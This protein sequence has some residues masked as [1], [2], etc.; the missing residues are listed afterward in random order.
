MPAVGVPTSSTAAAAGPTAAVK[1]P[2]MREDAAVPELREWSWNDNGT[3]S[4]C[5]YGH[6]N[7]HKGRKLSTSRIIEFSPVPASS[8]ESEEAEVGPRADAAG[9]RLRHF[10]VR[11]AASTLRE[12]TIV[13]TKSLAV[14]RLGKGTP[15]PAAP[16]SDTAQLQANP[17]P[18]AEQAASAS[19]STPGARASVLGSPARE[20]ESAGAAPATLETGGM[21]SRGMLSRGPEPNQAALATIEVEVGEKL[22]E[23]EPAGASLASLGMG[24]RPRVAESAGAAPA[25]LEL[26]GRLP[27]E[28]E[29]AGAPAAAPATMELGGRL[30][31]ETE[32]AGA[33]ATLLT[34][35]KSRPITAEFL[36][37]AQVAPT[38][39]SNI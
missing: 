39:Y 22:R 9:A 16:A 7:Y 14:Y 5:V 33:P 13:V 15:P 4:G 1:T 35:P 36:D 30:P 29:P 20:T 32:P 26:G 23:S 3:L 11:T 12:G 27:L 31:L 37:A 34:E 24:V 18:A 8:S 19:C 2:P 28:T 38:T 21:L 25:T 10:H 17:E 6:A